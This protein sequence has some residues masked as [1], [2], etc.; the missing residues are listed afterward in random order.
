MSLDYAIL[1]FISYIPLTGYELKK[2][3][4]SSVRHFWAADQSQIYRTLAQL[5]ADGLVEMEVAEQTN[6]PDRKVYSITPAGRQALQQWVEGP[7]S[8]GDPRNAILLNTFFMGKCT[9]EQVLAKFEEAAITIRG[10]LAAYEA[11]P[12]TISELSERLHSKREAFFWTLT[13]EW[14]IKTGRANLEWV[15]SVI[16]R[17]KKNQVPQE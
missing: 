14:G 4:D 13:L 8:G 11:A 15:E 7:F 1:G 6:R 16:D 10:L 5:T 2:L 12:K 17:I 3:F 9:D